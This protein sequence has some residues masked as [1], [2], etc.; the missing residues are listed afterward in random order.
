VWSSGCAINGTG[1]SVGQS[2]ADLTVTNIEQLRAIKGAAGLRVFVQGFRTINDGG[3]GIFV[4]KASSSIPVT[5]DDVGYVLA[6]KDSSLRWE[7]ETT[8]TDV[9][10]KWF[11]ATGDARS[12]D[13]LA[14]G[15]AALVAK[16]LKGRVYAPA[17]TYK[18]DGVS[19]RVAFGS[20]RLTTDRGAFTKLTEL[21]PATG[22]TLN[23]YAT[24]S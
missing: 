22:R 6:S 12:N 15:T 16:Q 14:V 10:V 5:T 21:V 8:S 13:A 3:E 17:G 9:S 20:V 19:K 4:L 2:Q 18:V 24:L 11:G 7:R 1:E 23:H